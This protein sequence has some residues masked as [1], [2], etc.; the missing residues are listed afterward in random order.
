MDDRSN[1]V[2]IHYMRDALSI[3]EHCVRMYEEGHKSFFRVAAAQLRILVCDT[4]FRHDRQVDIAIVP[5]LLPNLQLP[6]YT[7]DA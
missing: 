3:L 2:L 5:I 4:T 1:V 6:T 7:N